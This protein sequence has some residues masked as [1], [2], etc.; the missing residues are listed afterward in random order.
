MTGHP[1]TRRPGFG[2][3]VNRRERP[4]GLA[5]ASATCCLFKSS[6]RRLPTERAAPPR[7]RIGRHGPGRAVY[8]SAGGTFGVRGHAGRPP[9][10]VESPHPGC[11]RTSYEP[12]RRWCGRSMRSPR[13]GARR[14]CSAGHPGCGTWICTGGRCGCCV[15]AR[16]FEPAGVRVWTDASPAQAPSPLARYRRS[17]APSLI[18]RFRSGFGLTTALPRGADFR[19]VAVSVEQPFSTC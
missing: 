2:G 19:D 7:C 12:V 5:V 9:V 10:G 15:R 3:P 18:A 1:L 8:A 17:M 16:T 6:T 14:V 11:L 13:V 4:A